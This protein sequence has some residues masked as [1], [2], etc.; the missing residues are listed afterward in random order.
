MQWP[1]ESMKLSFGI[2]LLI[3]LLSAAVLYYFGSDVLEL[4][5]AADYSTIDFVMAAESEAKEIDAEETEEPMPAAGPDEAGPDEAGPEMAVPEE[6]EFEE[7]PDIVPQRQ[8][9]TPA[10]NPAPQPKVAEPLTN[11][12][13]VH[14]DRLSLDAG[15]LRIDYYFNLII[16][17]LRENW[18]PPYQAAAE[19]DTLAARVGFTIDRSGNI[20]NIK[21]ERSSGRFLYDQAAERAVYAIKQLPPLPDEYSGEALTVHIEFERL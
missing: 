8:P 9:R 20:T 2:S 5:A 4:S 18:R 19:Q 1:R 10:A 6:P 15:D 16:R 11:T 14:R 13:A 21:L 3:H 17:R 7:A 12:A